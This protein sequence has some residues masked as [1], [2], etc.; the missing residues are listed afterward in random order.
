[1]RR[2]SLIR[3]DL[4]FCDSTAIKKRAAPEVLPVCFSVYFFAESM[5]AWYVVS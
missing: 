2:H 1:M 5:I 3:P 4:L